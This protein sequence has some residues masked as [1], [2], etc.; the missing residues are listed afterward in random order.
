MD[1][2]RFEKGMRLMQ[3]ALTALSGGPF[4]YTLKCL[5]AA[6]M[7]LLTRYAPFKV[8]DRVALAVTPVIDEKTAWGWMSSKHFLIEGALGV[9]R[10]SDVRSDGQLFFDVEFDDETWIDREGV[11]RPVERKHTYC[12]GERSL[13]R[14]ETPNARGN[15]PDTAR[16]E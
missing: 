13:V 3:E 6:R 5:L 1:I 10:A 7:A 12:F 15:A 2:D 9:V 16:T 11:R 8:G 14:V 4:D